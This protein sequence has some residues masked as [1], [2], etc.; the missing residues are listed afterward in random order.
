MDQDIAIGVL[1]DDLLPLSSKTMETLQVFEEDGFFVVLGIMVSIIDDQWWK[2]SLDAKTTAELGKRDGNQF[3]ADTEQGISLSSQGG[4]STI[5]F[6][7][8]SDV[9]VKNDDDGEKDIDNSNNL[10]GV[11]KWRL[12]MKYLK[13]EKD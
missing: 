11:K 9:A 2:C 7:E 3:I 5:S 4:L 1:D 10:S 13:I 8:L 12:E 6:G